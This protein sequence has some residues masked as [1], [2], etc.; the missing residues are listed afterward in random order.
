MNK[1]KNSMVIATIAMG[2]ALPSFAQA[3]EPGLPDTEMTP[4]SRMAHDHGEHG[5]MHKK[6]RHGMHGS[7][8]QK[9]YML[10]LAE[11]YTPDSVAQWQEVF[12]ERERLMSEFAALREDPKWKAK[13]EERRQLVSKLNEQ[14]K[15]GEIT[16]E[17]ME[18]QLAQWKEKN[19]A[20]P[21]AKEDRD[22]RKARMEKMRMTH[23]AFHAAI[24][25]GDA[26]KIKEVLPQMLEQMK[27]KNALLA[28]KLEQR[29]K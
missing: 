23:E 29:K 25:S 19:M 14:V 15:K 6:M 11:K 26:A 21:G 16:N 18:Q 1:W 24:E 12:K 13:R 20:M 10:L 4:A 27:A 3:A 2:L 28:K 9:M 5:Q 7:V 8:H 22:A 17:Q